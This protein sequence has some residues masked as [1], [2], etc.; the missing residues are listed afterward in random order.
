MA[1]T[2][3]FVQRL[4]LTD[5]LILAW[6]YIGPTASNTELLVVLSGTGQPPDEVVVVEP[7]AR[8]AVA[9][10][11]VPGGTRITIPEF[12]LTAAVV[13]TNDLTGEN[14][15]LDYFQSQC[16]RRRKQAEHRCRDLPVRGT[17]DEWALHIVSDMEKRLSVAQFNVP[18]TL[19]EHDS[20]S[21]LRVELHR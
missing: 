16:R 8:S 19:G 21:R 7:E 6:A 4:K 14:S 20:D 5:T 13:F 9:M 11:R 3:G 15:L 18:C 17:H 1:Q 10:E 12:G 2:Q